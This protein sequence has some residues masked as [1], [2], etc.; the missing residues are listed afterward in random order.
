ME[1]VSG[2]L[3]VALLVAP[4]DLSCQ[5]AAAS[6]ARQPSLITEASNKAAFVSVPEGCAV[7]P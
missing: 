7:A 3:D 2:F 6:S 4:L 1:E 5:C